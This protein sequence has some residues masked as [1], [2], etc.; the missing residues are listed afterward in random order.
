MMITLKNEFHHTEARVRV[1]DVETYE[2]LGKVFLSGELS[3]RQISRARAK[4]C[5][6][7]HCSCGSFRALEQMVWDGAPNTGGVFEVAKA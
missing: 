2:F 7:P 3:P 6:N 1:R 4:L 5:G